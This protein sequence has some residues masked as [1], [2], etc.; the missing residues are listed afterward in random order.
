M[1]RVDYGDDAGAWLKEPDRTVATEPEQCCECERTIE[2]G[3]TMTYFEWTYDLDEDGEP[4]PD[5][6]AN[7]SEQF[8]VHC[9]AAAIWLDEVCSGHLYGKWQII[10]D[11]E[12]HWDEE[13]Y[14]IK[15]IDLG[16]LLVGMKKQWKR[17][18]GSRTPVSVIKGWAKAGA[19]RAMAGVS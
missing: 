8:C 18:D 6:K 1:C 2:S 3:E 11:L 4:L 9:E 16:R 17:K 7:Y 5:A 13:G 10:E 12:E 15:T 14:P 19:K